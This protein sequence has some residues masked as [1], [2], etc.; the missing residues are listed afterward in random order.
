MASDENVEDSIGYLTEYIRD[1][2]ARIAALENGF[3]SAQQKIAR[4]DDKVSRLESANSSLHDE[5]LTLR[6]AL[7]VQQE[8]PRDA[9]TELRN[10]IPREEI[11][12]LQKRLSIDVENLEVSADMRH[13]D[14]ATRN[15]Q[16]VEETTA[17]TATGQ[18]SQSAPDS[19]PKQ[20]RSNNAQPQCTPVSPMR[21]PTPNP[22]PEPVVRPPSTCA[23]HQ[24]TS[25]PVEPP[26]VTG[27]KRGP[28]GGALHE[29]PPSKRITRSRG[30]LVPGSFVHFQAPADPQPPTQPPFPP[31]ATT[32]KPQAKRKCASCLSTTHM[33]P[34]CPVTLGSKLRREQ[35]DLVHHIHIHST[36]AHPVQ[37]RLS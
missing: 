29:A 22:A 32:K 31:E 25:T 8:P 34:M 35:R 3:E 13:L 5:V 7:S 11:A 1:S 37:L 28:P 9:Q 15:L 17:V 12:A 14:P 20:L 10:V 24:P 26:V 6:G 18:A 27:V 2:H 23:R 16:A 21:E 36:S 30:E 4:L 19:A 33:A